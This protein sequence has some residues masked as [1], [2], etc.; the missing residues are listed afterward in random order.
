MIDFLLS[1]DSFKSNEFAKKVE[2]IKTFAASD[3]DVSVSLFPRFLEEAAV[4]L[5]EIENVSICSLSQFASRT[6]PEVT[7][8]EVAMAVE[9][10]ADEIEIP[11]DVIAI[12]SGNL[13]LAVGEVK[14]IAEEI[15]GAA[16]LSVVVDS[17]LFASFDLYKKVVLSVIEAGADVIMI[18]NCHADV[19]SIKYLPETL[20]LIDSQENGSK[21]KL[22]VK[23]DVVSDEGKV[24]NLFLKYKDHIIRSII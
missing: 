23:G 17:S 16:T 7:I 20:E 4:A 1:L 11:L 15:N 14:V 10:G 18:N 24:S 19:D 8:L 5:N 21:I 9:N 12:D 2:K 13:D 22:F 3:V 6:Y